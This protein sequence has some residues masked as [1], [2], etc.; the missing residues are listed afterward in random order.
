V[1]TVHP[2]V[3]VDLVPDGFF[4]PAYK[5]RLKLLENSASALISYA[6]CENAPEWLLNAN[7]IVRDAAG[8]GRDE[9]LLFIAGAETIAD[10][11]CCGGLV[12]ISPCS[13]EMTAAWQGSRFG[14]RS[15]EYRRFKDQAGARLLQRLN[16]IQEFSG[17]LTP[18]E[19]ATPLTLRDYSNNPGGGLYGVKHKV[20]QYNPQPVTKLPGLLLAGQAVAGPGLFGTMLSSFLACGSVLGNEMLREDVKRC[21]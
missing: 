15:D 17:Q 8:S 13:A 12:V 20:G 3:L 11:Q 2:R 7:L 21:S 10:P 18:V 19:L 9:D 16:S 5:K 1:A 6:A 4:R 14:Q